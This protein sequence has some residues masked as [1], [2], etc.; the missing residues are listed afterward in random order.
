MFVERL[1]GDLRCDPR[2]PV[3]TR[4]FFGSATALRPESV[5]CADLDAILGRLGLDPASFRAEPG[6]D[7]LVILRHTLMN[8]YLVDEEN[9]ISYIELYFEHL[10]HQVRAL[11]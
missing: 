7:R 4:Q 10:A 5:G 9:G 8:P 6:S 2:Q 3:Q 1:H 11:L